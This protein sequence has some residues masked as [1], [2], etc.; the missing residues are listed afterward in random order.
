MFLGNGTEYY[1][2]LDESTSNIELTIY[3]T[4]VVESTR[5]LGPK[6]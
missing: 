3:T 6:R 2:I 1:I 5:Q 4:S